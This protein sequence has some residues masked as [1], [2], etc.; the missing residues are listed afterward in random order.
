MVARLVNRGKTSGR[1]DDNEETIKKRLE[2]FSAVSFFLFSGDYQSNN[3]NFKK[4]PPS[5]WLPTTSNRENCSKSSV[6]LPSP[7]PM[8]SSQR[9]VS[10][11]KNCKKSLYTDCK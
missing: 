10:S 4:R 6:R 11:L 8:K 7:R 9:S 5:P 1:A 3:E 2:T